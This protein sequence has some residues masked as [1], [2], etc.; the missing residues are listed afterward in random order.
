[1]TLLDY[2]N[3]HLIEEQ[4]L[5]ARTHISAA[6]L[7]KWQA[8]R[9]APQPSYRLS[10]AINSNSCFGDHVENHTFAYYPHGTPLW[11]GTITSM[12]NEQ[13]AF[14]HFV[15]RYRATATSLC[16]DEH[17][18]DT[19]LDEQYLQEE[20]QHFLDGTYGVCTKSGLPEAIAIKDLSVTAIE[21]LLTQSNPDRQTLH[22]LID[23]LD[24]VSAPFAP[25]ERQKS[26]RQRLITELRQRYPLN[27][28]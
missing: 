7:A 8:E 27:N 18:D 9:L 5:L 20:W 13:Q 4:T 3:T 15:E 1:M 14:A 28:V 11:L 19:H 17:I 25:H 10:L 26:S 22:Q 2:L 24:E 12:H 6:Q 21:K 23:L 16:A